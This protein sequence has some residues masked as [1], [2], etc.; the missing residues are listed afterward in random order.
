[1]HR[2]HARPS[3]PVV[4]D[5][6]P[7]PA[8]PGV[9]QLHD[10]AAIDSLLH[11]AA[12]VGPAVVYFVFYAPLNSRSIKCSIKILGAEFLQQKA[13]GVGLYHLSI[14]RFCYS[15]ACKIIQENYIVGIRTSNIWALGTLDTKHCKGQE[16]NGLVFECLGLKPD[17][18]LQSPSGENQAFSSQYCTNYFIGS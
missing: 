6:K 8:K 9:I 4:P 2:R 15:A 1:M 17:L 12:V 5:P 11:T 16:S 14:T 7:G 18:K 3:L 13:L 10:T